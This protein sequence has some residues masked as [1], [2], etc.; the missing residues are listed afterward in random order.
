[1]SINAVV[2][3]LKTVAHSPVYTH[4]HKHTQRLRDTAIDAVVVTLKPVT[5]FPVYSRAEMQAEAM[6]RAGFFI[7][8]PLA[9]AHHLI[10]EWALH[11]GPW[12]PAPLPP[13]AAK[14]TGGP[15]TKL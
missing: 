6:E 3:T 9:I 5:H 11:D 2:V 14:R 13:V 7:P 8:P 10:R 15:S 1:M 4:A 12:F